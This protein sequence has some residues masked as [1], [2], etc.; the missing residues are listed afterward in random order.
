MFNFLFNS[1]SDKLF[2]FVYD[3]PDSYFHSRKECTLLITSD[4]LVNAVKEFH[5]MTDNKVRHISDVIEIVYP[6]VRKEE[7][8]DISGK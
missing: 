1:R 7:G 3:S 4:C 5:H 8:V 2:K 6:A